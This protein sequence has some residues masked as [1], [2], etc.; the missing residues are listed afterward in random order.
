MN[1]GGGGNDNIAKF[2]FANLSDGNGLPGNG[3]GEGQNS[4]LPNE[5]F[6]QIALFGSWKP[7]AEKFNLGSYRQNRAAFDNGLYKR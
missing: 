5:G 3:I 6:D 1:E 4:T 7:P 2:D